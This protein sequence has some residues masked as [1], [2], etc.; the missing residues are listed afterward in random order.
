MLF[1]LNNFLYFIVETI[2]NTRL[3]DSIDINACD[4]DGW[5]P[6]MA[7]C[8]WQQ[9]ECVQILLHHNAS[10]TMTSSNGLTCES[11]CN[12]NTIILQLL[13]TKHKQ[14][15]QIQNEN[16]SETQRRLHAKKVRETRR[17]TQGIKQEDVTA[18]IQLFKS[19]NNIPFMIHS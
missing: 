9:T 3:K 2:L 16:S 18:A 15:E 6:L 17:S 8:H 10:I 13:Q 1:Q 14:L 5:T 19:I 4:S 11:L 12:D 7:A